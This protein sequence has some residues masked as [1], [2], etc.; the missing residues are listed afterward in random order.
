M[1]D[2]QNRPISLR[3]VSVL[4]FGGWI[5]WLWRK[6]KKN[7]SIAVHFGCSRWR[8]DIRLTVF[9][10]CDFSVKNLAEKNLCLCNLAV[11]FVGG[12][13]ECQNDQQRNSHDRNGNHV[14][15]SETRLKISTGDFFWQHHA[16]RRLQKLLD[17]SRYF[18]KKTK[19]ID[20]WCDALANCIS[21]EITC[22]KLQVIFAFGGEF[23]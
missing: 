21:N 5:G 22:K 18:V 16:E 1:L 19:Y 7:F 3:E 2:I 6:R 20:F 11:R 8:W 9:V 13:P 14:N 4:R 23:L 17:F 10:I 15:G 12:K